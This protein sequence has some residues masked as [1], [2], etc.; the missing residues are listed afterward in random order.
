MLNG[1]VWWAKGGFEYDA[2]PRHVE[3]VIEQLDVAT[4]RSVTTPGLDWTDDD[5]NPAYDE[6]LT[7]YDQTPRSTIAA[8]MNYLAMDCQVFQCSVKECCRDMAC[9]TPRS[10]KRLHRIGC[11]LNAHPRL[12]LERPHAASD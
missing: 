6:D 4:A 5:L 3:I 11:Y 1:V 10:L 9:P 7:N 8:R 2:G 12:V